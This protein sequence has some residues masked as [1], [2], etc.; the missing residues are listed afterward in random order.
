MTNINQLIKENKKMKDEKKKSIRK[1]IQYHKL[2]IEKYSYK[3]VHNTSTIEDNLKY[4]ESK[5]A[6]KYLYDLIVNIDKG[7]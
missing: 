2:Q 3:W 5:Q 1:R 7:E 6:L 4:E